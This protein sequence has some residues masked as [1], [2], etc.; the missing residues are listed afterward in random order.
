MPKPRERIL[1][2][3]NF[4]TPDRLPKDL[5]GMRSTGI[6]AF[7]YPKLVNALGLPPR[8]PRV[9]DTMQMLALPDLDVLDALGCDVV[10]ICEGATNAF[11]Q[12]ELWHAYEF[13]GRLPALVRHPE[14]YSVELDGTI[15]QGSLRMPPSS[16]V[17]DELHGGQPLDLS[18][19]LPKFDLKLVKPE[20][21]KRTPT[22]E[23][24]I[25]LRNLC[26]RVRE[27]TDRAVFFNDSLLQLPIGIGSFGGLGIFPVLCLTE[28]DWVS[29]LHEIITAHYVKNVQTILPEISPYIDIIMLSADD[30][31]TQNNLIASPQLYKQLFLPYLRQLNGTCH[32]IAPDV[33]MFL[34]CCGAIFDLI[35]LVIEAGFDV[36]NP[37]QW[38][39]G[40]HSYQ[41]WKDKCRDR[42]ALW[43]G[44]VDSQRTL[45]LG[46]VEDVN[47]QVSEVTDYL[48]QGGGYVFCNIHNILA[49]IAPEKIIGM[50]RAASNGS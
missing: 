30:W 21:E 22:D 17:F 33:K 18:A 40:G 2:A 7:A 9:E 28:P 25:A 31:G 45:P 29:E 50:Y 16:Y 6:S 42:I 3:L 27:S 4:Q 5:G 15:F 26:R 14:N 49:E 39:A 46:T 44:G 47:K 36:L 48:S 19:D 8:R 1:Q 32:D 11:E 35:D 37:V 20:L 12:P 38:T 41:E 43:G 34:H 24:I 23:K 13:N 10:T